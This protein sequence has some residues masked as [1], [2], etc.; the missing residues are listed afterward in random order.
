ML[1]LMRYTKSV[2]IVRE[3]ENF[4]KWIKGLKDKIALSLITARIR[5][6]STGNLGDTKPVGSGVF[7][8]RIDYGPGYRVYFIQR[9]RK[10]IVLL[11]GGIKTSQTRN[12]ESAKRIAEKLEEV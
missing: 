4:R 10:I 11:C 8:L 7:E 1:Y 9:G 3:T 12:I 6:I 5:R 2:I